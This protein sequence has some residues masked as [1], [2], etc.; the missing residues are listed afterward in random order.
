MKTR[1]K[2]I[3]FGTGVF[4][5]S[6]KK[7]LSRKTEIVAFI[8][9][10]E[11]RQG[12]Y[13]D[14]A[15][16]YSPLEVENLE[17]DFIVLA[18]VTPG[19]MR[20]QLLQQNVPDKKIMFWEEYMGY[21]FHGELIKYNITMFN[22]TQKKCLIVVPIINFA[23]G[24]LSVLYVAVVLKKLEIGVVIVSPTA[25]EETIKE[26]NRQGINVWVCPALP[27]IEKEELSWI[28]TF[29]FV[30]ANS[31]QTMLCVDRI[32]KFKPMIWWLHEN[33]KQYEEIM[34]QYG[35][36][37]EDRNFCEADIYAV[38]DIAKKNFVERFPDTEVSLLG[39]GIP[40]FYVEST[41]I[42]S[43]INIA[44][45]GALCGI[46]NQKEIVKA[47]ECLPDSE[48]GKIECWFIGKDGE[49]RYKDELKEMIKEQSNIKILGEV[50]RE[51]LQSLFAYIDIVVCCSVEETF[52]IV[53]AEGL[54]NKKICITT[55]NTGI[56]EFIIDGVNGFV[57]KE[58]N[59]EELAQKLF[60]VLQNFNKLNYIRDNAR[61]TYEKYLS[62]EV[63]EDR[64]KKVIEKLGDK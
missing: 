19:A 25:N 51:N 56:A 64:I 42:N 26:V 34:G 37:I 54:M 32:S 62:L 52:S 9:N 57:Y 14:N 49:R 1:K 17:Y 30:W 22:E 21:Q 58:G 43:K 4:Y 33:S 53:I 47:I 15:I 36:W 18:S 44:V 5:S 50:D 40:D 3:V 10:D 46:K 13:F 12:T 38:S 23:G 24:F 45:I 39:L 31:L 48:K 27:Y 55:K 41:A 61:K 60:H 59:I 11:S 28:K 16:I 35:K 20:K 2:I 6:R 7:M 8:D 29:D 63:F